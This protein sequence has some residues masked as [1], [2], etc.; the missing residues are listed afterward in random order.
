[1]LIHAGLAVMSFYKVMLVVINVHEITAR[2][3]W[4]TFQSFTLSHTYA[5]LNSLSL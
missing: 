5:I 1:V 4:D 2:H 3:R